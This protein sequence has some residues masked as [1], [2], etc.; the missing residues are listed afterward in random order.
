MPFGSILGVVLDYVLSIL[1][2][3]SMLFSCIIFDASNRQ[4]ATY[5]AVAA[6]MHSYYGIM[7]VQFFSDLQCFCGRMEAW[8]RPCEAVAAGL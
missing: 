1:S 6:D 7:F 4:M 5:F 3:M 2:A 8:P